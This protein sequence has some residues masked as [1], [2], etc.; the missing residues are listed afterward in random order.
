MNTNNNKVSD[1]SNVVKLSRVLPQSMAIVKAGTHLHSI[2]LSLYKPSLNA[3][4][5]PFKHPLLVF[6]TIFL[7]ILR[8]MI[9]IIIPEQNQ[10]FY[11]ITGDWFYFLGMRLQ[12]SLI[13]IIGLSIP[14]MSQLIHYYNYKNGVK[15]TDLRVFQMLSGSTGTHALCCNTTALLGPAS[16]GS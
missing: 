10:Q 13:C 8:Q 9:V 15:P 6:M 7:L 5:N 12:L 2:G 4:R 16:G 11:A 14:L 3:Y 1:N